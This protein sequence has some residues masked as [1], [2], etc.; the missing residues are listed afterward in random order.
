MRGF[1]FSKYYYYYYGVVENY[2]VKFKDV[3]EAIT[4]SSL[5]ISKINNN[6]K[7]YS[8]KSQ[9]KINNEPLQ[10]KIIDSKTAYITIQKFGN[11]KIKEERKSKKPKDWF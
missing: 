10:F 8:N 5:P 4:F 9:E 7:K 3:A 6:L 2:N 1:N 11:Y